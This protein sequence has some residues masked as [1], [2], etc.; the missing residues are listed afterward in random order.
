MSESLACSPTDALQVGCFW[1]ERKFRY[2]RMH[3]YIRHEWAAE[4]RQIEPFACRAVQ[5]DNSTFSSV[6]G[7]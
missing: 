4:P 3:D 7:T 6:G 1:R 5:L 2:V